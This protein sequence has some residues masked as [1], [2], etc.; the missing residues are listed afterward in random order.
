MK[1]GQAEDF[2]NSTGLMG[3]YNG[4]IWYG[5]DGVTVFQTENDFGM[6]LQVQQVDGLLFTTP[7]P[8]PDKCE[9]ITLDTTSRRLSESVVS[10]EDAAQA[11]MKWG[12]ETGY[13]SCMFDVMVSDDLE[14]A[15]AGPY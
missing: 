12:S 8:F 3:S 2:M 13:E 4:G 9:I 11:C 5:R 15:D 7:S 6:E 10:H 1:N 14:M